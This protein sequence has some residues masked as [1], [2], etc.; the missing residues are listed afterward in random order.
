MPIQSLVLLAALAAGSA[1][2]DRSQALPR[3]PAVE[4]GL[5]APIDRLDTVEGFARRLGER[6]V[7]SVRDGDAG[8]VRFTAIRIDRGRVTAS[9][10]SDPVYLRG[11]LH[12]VLSAIGEKAFAGFPDVCLT[13]DD[14]PARVL[15]VSGKARLDGEELEQVIVEMT[16]TGAFP[17]RLALDGPPEVEWGR[18]VILV[19]AASS[20]SAEVVVR[21]L[22]LVL[23]RT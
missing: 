17:H 23:E 13:P 3:V 2:V 6:L 14:P 1:P 5:S 18:D 19:L 12:P 20:E 9:Y 22:I 10:Q 11:G 21:P 7:W 8:A 4:V 16:R 15:A